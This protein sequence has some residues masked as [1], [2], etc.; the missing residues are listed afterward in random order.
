MSKAISYRINERHEQT[1]PLRNFKGRKI[2]TTKYA[3]STFDLF[4]QHSITAF[5]TSSLVQDTLTAD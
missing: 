2:G 1:S 3:T 5:T 4:R